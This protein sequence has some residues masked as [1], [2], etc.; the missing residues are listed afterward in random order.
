[1]HWAAAVFSC[2][3][4]CVGSA[5]TQA[6][7]LKVVIVQGQGVTNNVG[8]GSLQTLEVQIRDDNDKPVSGANVTFLLPERGPG[9]TFLG[10]YNKMN[11]TTNEEGNAIAN[12]FQPNLI[13]G[14]FQIHVIAAQ[15]DR[16][17][18]GDINQTNVVQSKDLTPTGTA[19]GGLI[20]R[21]KSIK[22]SR[23]TKIIAAVATGAVVVLIATTAGGGGSTSVT[24]S[25]ATSILPG[26][27]AVGAPR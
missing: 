4:T 13:Q 9:G 6:R 20:T 19:N 17:G 24:S 2:F 26:T 12:S 7:P 22:L 10:T 16:T 5:N 23:R 21:L 11:L 1:M 3:M 15:G 8:N 18:S 14:R 27:V 25:T